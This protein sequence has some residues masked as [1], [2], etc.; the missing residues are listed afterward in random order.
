MINKLKQPAVTDK[1]DN[2]KENKPLIK[3]KDKKMNIKKTKMK[4]G[5]QR[6]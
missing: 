4:R 6:N 5:K 3:G 1:E 2:T